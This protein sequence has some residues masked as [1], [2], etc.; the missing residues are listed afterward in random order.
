M[1]RGASSVHGPAF[2]FRRATGSL[3]ANGNMH[4]SKRS[5]LGL[6]KGTGKTMRRGD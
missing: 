4:G 2:V 3:D 5:A 1:A 6:G